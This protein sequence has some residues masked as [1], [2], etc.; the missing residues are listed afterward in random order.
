M[1]RYFVP[2]EGTR[3][4]FE[5]PVSKPGREK[6]APKKNV[7]TVRYMRK[8]ADLDGAWEG[9]STRA[10]TSGSR[11]S[12]RRQECIDLSRSRSREGWIGVIT[13]REYSKERNSIKLVEEILSIRDDIVVSSS[14]KGEQL[15]TLITVRYGGPPSCTAI[16]DFQRDCRATKCRSRLCPAKWHRYVYL[17]ITRR[18]NV[19]RTQVFTCAT[20]P[21]LHT[22]CTK[23]HTYVRAHT[24]RLASRQRL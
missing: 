6:G 2:R 13:A 4:P 18:W 23:T 24:I 19:V 12:S 20:G 21:H 17:S 5:L 15:H 8:D 1:T 9:G 3:T 11:K 10:C 7:P 22:L 16:R 14:F